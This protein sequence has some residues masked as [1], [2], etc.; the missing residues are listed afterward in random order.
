M[1]FLGFIFIITTTLVMVFK[2]ETVNNEPSKEDKL[3]EDRGHVKNYEDKLTTK[4]TYKLM[5]RL[6]HI[7]PVKKLIVILLT[8][9]VRKICFV[10]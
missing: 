2:T 10:F 8:M 3:E 1:H 5:W 6:L 4:S 7:A 9:K